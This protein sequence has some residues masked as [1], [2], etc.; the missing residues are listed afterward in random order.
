LVG[1][2]HG[3]S[4]EFFKNGGSRLKLDILGPF[5]PSVKLMVRVED[6]DIGIE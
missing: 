6:G 4:F 1:S 5:S 3:S 2:R